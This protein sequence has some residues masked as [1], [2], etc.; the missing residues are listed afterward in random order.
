M[1]LLNTTCL[2]SR[3]GVPQPRWQGQ[4]QVYSA[5]QHQCSLSPEGH[6]TLNLQ[7]TFQAQQLCVQSNMEQH[8]PA[9]GMRQGEEGLQGLHS[10]LCAMLPPRL[11]ESS[12]PTTLISPRYKKTSS[13]HSKVNTHQAS[14]STSMLSAA[15]I[16][17]STEGCLEPHL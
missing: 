17:S 14:N 1:Y 3:H 15:E 11:L 7:D 12:A 13:T 5:A 10:R 2:Q 16:L 9:E 6:H 8:L 4:Y